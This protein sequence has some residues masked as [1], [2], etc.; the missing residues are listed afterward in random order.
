MGEEGKEE[1]EG[2]MSY[3][4]W[5]GEGKSLVVVDFA[6]TGRRGGIAT[7]AKRTAEERSEAARKAAIARWS[8]RKAKKKR[9]A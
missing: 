4:E 9:K 3:E 1:E 5:E 2:V 7:A 8:G 6:E